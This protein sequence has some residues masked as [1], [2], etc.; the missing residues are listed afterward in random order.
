MTVAGTV[1]DFLFFALV[2]ATVF[3]ERTSNVFPPTL[4]VVPITV[5]ELV[6]GSTGVGSTGVV[7]DASEVMS[8]PA[9]TSI[10]V[11]LSRSLSVVLL[12]E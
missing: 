12:S 10:V 3:A 9:F 1:T 2:K 6:A 5:F 7:V 4:I 11:T 8:L